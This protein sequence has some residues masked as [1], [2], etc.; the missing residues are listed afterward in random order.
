VVIAR[1]PDGDHWIEAPGAGGCAVAPDG[2]TIRYIPGP[3]GGVRL[4]LDQA[5]PFAACAA[6]VECLH[7]SAVALDGGAVAF[8]GVSGAGKSS[9]ALALARRGAR[10]LAD[11]VLALEPAP[12]GALLA[13]AA[14]PRMGVRRTEAVRAG[15]AGGALGALAP[16]DA[17]SL[18]LALTT[19]EPVAPLRL[20]ALY[21][22]DRRSE[23]VPFAFAPVDDPRLVL[24][25]S[26]NFVL[27]VPER[28]VR[29]LD[30]CHRLVTHAHVRRAVVPPS[31]APEALADAVLADVAELA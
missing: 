3:D 5:L 24:A 13:H 10:P 23:E 30:L 12:S 4:L 25:C 15:V 31:V 19:A 20:R 2:G 17:D 21:V 1:M 18:L 6:G 27:A 9:L 14:L 8:A 11:D 29:L 28:L 22:L 26:F 7:A 16:R